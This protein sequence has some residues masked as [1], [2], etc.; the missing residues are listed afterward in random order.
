M[1]SRAKASLRSVSGNK[2]T[3]ERSH[4]CLFTHCFWLLSTS[5]KWSSCYRDQCPMKP[6]IFIINLL[7]NKFGNPCPCAIVFFHKGH[8][9]DS[10]RSKELWCVSGQQEGCQLLKMPVCK[11]MEFPA[12]SSASHQAGCEG[13]LGRTS[14]D[15][16]VRDTDLGGTY[17]GC[18]SLSPVENCTNE[19]KGNPSLLSHRGLAS[20]IALCAGHRLHFT[21]PGSLRLLRDA[22]PSLGTRLK[23]A[24][25]PQRRKEVQINGKKGRA[26]W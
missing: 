22:I 17:V 20:G 24:N 11:L 10:G 7:R 19:R 12:V 4:T 1:D 5:P 25:V 3:L 13:K 8:S 16:T 6:K 15:R 26:V 23:A 14:R 18:S 21:R 2:V 9:R